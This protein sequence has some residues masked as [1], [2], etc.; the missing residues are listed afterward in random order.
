MDR[1][2][3]G[4][5]PA[6]GEGKRMG[7][8]SQILPKC[9][10]PLYNKPI[11]HR[12]VDNMRQVGA[13]EIYVIVNYQKDRI[14][15][16]FR[17]VEDSIDLNIRFMVQE[18]LLGI[19]DAIMLT[20]EYISEPFMVVLG[21]DCTIAS[22]L[23]NLTETFFANDSIVVEGMVKES[24]L[25]K[26]RSACCV[27]LDGGKEIVRIVEKPEN[28]SSNLRGCGIYVF[29]PDIF[30]YI[31]RTPISK[32]RNEIEI[33]HTIDMVSKDGRAYGEFINGI[34]LNINSYEDLLQASALIRESDFGI[35][36]IT[37]DRPSLRKTA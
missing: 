25:S 28:P 11:I 7:Y 2:R 31:Q 13:E 14:I 18:P 5:I 3:V 37:A 30:D 20:R 8:L 12:V 29:H 15:E 23:D 34:N 22:S 16:Y 10:F 36:P 35:D 26:L 17:S 6:A 24:D 9:L 27:T 4:V 33:T 32:L 1:I 21:D 19:A